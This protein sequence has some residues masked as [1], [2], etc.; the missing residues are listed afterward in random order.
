MLLGDSVERGEHQRQDDLAVLLYQAKDV[1][2]V[3]EVKSSLRYLKPPHTEKKKRI[4]R[5]SFIRHGFVSFCADSSPGS[6]G[7]KY[8]RRSVW[9]GAPECGWTETALSRPESPRSRPGTS[10][11]HSRG[12]TQTKKKACQSQRRNAASSSSCLQ[13]HLFLCAGFRP[14]L[15][16]PSDDLHTRH[17]HTPTS[18]LCLTDQQHSLCGLC[19]HEWERKLE[20]KDSKGP[21]F[22]WIISKNG[23]YLN[24]KYKRKKCNEKLEV[25]SSYS[26]IVSGSAYKFSDCRVFLHELHHTV[27]QLQQ[28]NKSHTDSKSPAECEP[29]LPAAFHAVSV[30]Q[31]QCLHRSSL[32]SSKRSSFPNYLWGASRWERFV[33][34]FSAKPG[35]PRVVM[36]TETVC[37]YVGRS[38]VESLRGGSEAEFTTQLRGFLGC[39]GPH[40]KNMNF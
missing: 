33:F 10:P 21:L 20:R 23:R 12:V 16:Q 6:G 37:V 14:V 9:R 35:C 11:E 13:P 24:K 17:E 5:A 29:W 18:K 30:F 3:P 7:W 39:Y 38:D 26:S 34:V 28:H 32:I 1:L 19:F 31:Y 15:E 22:G 4:I 27:G 25:W 2:I 8:R 40:G 36:E